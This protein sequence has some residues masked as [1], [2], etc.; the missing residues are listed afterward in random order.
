VC[1]YVVRFRNHR[2]ILNKNGVKFQLC[3]LHVDR[4]GQW[5]ETLHHPAY[6]ELL[7]PDFNDRRY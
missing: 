7:P 4:V 6:V 1:N 5:L 3:V 2:V